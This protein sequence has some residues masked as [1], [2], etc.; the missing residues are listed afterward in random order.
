MK[1]L[2]FI[3]M[4]LILCSCSSG[5]KT[6][7]YLLYNLDPLFVNETSMTPA[8]LYSKANC[9]YSGREYSFGLPLTESQLNQLSEYKQ[10]NLYPFYSI[11]SSS[12]SIDLWVDDQLMDAHFHPIYL[13]PY[14]DKEDIS[15]IKTTFQ[16]SQEGEIYLSSMFADLGK[17]NIDGEE[18]PLREYIDYQ[19]DKKVNVKLELNIP[20]TIEEDQEYF[21]FNNVLYGPYQISRYSSY[22]ISEVFTIDGI[23]NFSNVYFDGGC[24]VLIPYELFQQYIKDIPFQCTWL[25]ETK[26]A[27]E[28]IEAILD[29]LGIC[30]V[31]LN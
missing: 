22:P 19:E 27:S 5:E 12:G 8:A 15:E 29:E 11:Y 24:S 30:Y 7:K 13:V 17:I 4:I 31:S 21:D 16:H 6:R 20:Q 10:I 1:K 14:F 9:I 28:K 26:M 25:I 18:I 2:Y 3:F 23:L